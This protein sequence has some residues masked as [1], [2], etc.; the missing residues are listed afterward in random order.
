[1]QWLLDST[2]HLTEICTAAKWKFKDCVA[3]LIA[4]GILE[5]DARTFTCWAFG[6]DA[7]FQNAI[8][9]ESLTEDQYARLSIT[10]SV[11]PE[12]SAGPPI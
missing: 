3:A 5:D 10:A 7:I 11:P 6:T 1:M 12:H 2:I 9:D 4:Q 8:G